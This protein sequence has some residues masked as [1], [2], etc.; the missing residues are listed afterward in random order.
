MEVEGGGENMDPG[1]QRIAYLR[2]ARPLSPLSPLPNPPPEDFL[3]DSVG[4]PYGIPLGI[5]LGSHRGSQENPKGNPQSMGIDN[6]GGGGGGKQVH[7]V[8][9]IAY[10]RHALPLDPFSA[11]PPPNIHPP[12]R[13][14][15]GF[16]VA[17]L[18]EFPWD[19]LWDPIGD[20][21]VIP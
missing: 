12:L 17:F 8:Q 18:M 3:W 10:L 16:P 7:R 6:R 1:V 20:P 4:I 2:R 11:F 15:C 19:F 13:I 9:R 5:L 14:P 21:K